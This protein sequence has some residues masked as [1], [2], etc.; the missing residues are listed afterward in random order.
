VTV[1]LLNYDGYEVDD[2]V[3]RLHVAFLH[4]YTLWMRLKLVEGQC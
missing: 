4:R 1:F 3:F 2:G